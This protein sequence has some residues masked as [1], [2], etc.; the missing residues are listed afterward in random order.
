MRQIVIL[1][2]ATLA[3][4]GCNIKS[5]EFKCIDPDFRH[6]D[7][8]I[9]D[10]EFWTNEVNVNGV[11]F[12]MAIPTRSDGSVYK[13]AALKHGA[14]DLYAS[15]E[16]YSKSSGRGFRLEVVRENNSIEGIQFVIRRP[17]KDVYFQCSQ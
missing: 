15:Y 4:A 10:L 16:K 8:V 2:A 17:G 12:K 3:L 13:E 14:P 7:V 9:S 1:I 11:A 6:P 5:D